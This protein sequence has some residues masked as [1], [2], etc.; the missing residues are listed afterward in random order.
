L[1]DKEFEVHVDVEYLAGSQAVHEIDVSLFDHAS[2]ER[3]RT[4]P[5]SMPGT[6]PLRG[7]IECKFYD[8][9]LGTALGRTFVGLV[10]DCGS[11]VV[12]AFVTNGTSTGIANYLRAG[13]RPTP[14]FNISPLVP[15][16]ADRFVGNVDQLLRQWAGVA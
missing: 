3:V 14:F 15:T 11:L 2:A 7:A 6:R 10:A 12:K 8:S 1:N 13:S 4:P 16:A 5:S 9:S